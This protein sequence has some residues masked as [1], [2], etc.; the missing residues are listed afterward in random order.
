MAKKQQEDNRDIFEKLLDD[1]ALPVS[2]AVLGRAAGRSAA[3][4]I[5]LEA[6]TGSRFPL[7]Q[8]VGGLSG[9]AGGAALGTKIN[10][11]RKLRA[12]GRGK[13]K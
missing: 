12:K 9:L 8:S 11:E 1:Y 7:V 6:R 5:G 3:K 2:G 10:D 13:R 4:R